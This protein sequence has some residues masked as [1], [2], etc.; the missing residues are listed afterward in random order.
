MHVLLPSWTRHHEA[1]PNIQW[2]PL[3]RPAE[4]CWKNT[5]TSFSP[6]THHCEHLFCWSSPTLLLVL[7]RNAFCRQL[8]KLWSCT[9]Q[10]RSTETRK[11]AD[12]LFTQPGHIKNWQLFLAC[13]FR[14][15]R[16]CCPSPGTQPYGFVFS[17]FECMFLLCLH[18]PW[19]VEGKVYLASSAFAEKHSLSQRAQILCGNREVGPLHLCWTN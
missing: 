7:S 6:S 11:E 17:P 13:T 19:L 14:G 10:R 2:L 9:Q 15:E 8:Q 5:V 4:N 12:I 16:Y 18:L 3:T 1:L